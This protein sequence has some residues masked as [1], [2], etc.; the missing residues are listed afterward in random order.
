MSDWKDWKRN[1]IVFGLILPLVIAFLIII[2]PTELRSVLNSVDSSGGLT[3]ILVDGLGEALLTVAIP[4]FL[5]L[6]WNQWAGG[7]AGFLLGSVYALYVNDTY[8]AFQMVEPTTMMVADVSTLAYVVTAMLVGYMAGALNRGSFSFKRMVVS[9]LIAGIISALMLV[10]AQ[11][12]PS[13]G[14]LSSVSMIDD[15]VYAVFITL[16]PRIIYGI[17]VPIFATVF[18][19]YGFSPRQMT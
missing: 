12:P 19:W 7:A 9:A 6:L 15:V 13:L 16:L 3:A 10:W 14:G 2:F 4:L 17:I 8:A 5:G 18:G 11:L 1:D